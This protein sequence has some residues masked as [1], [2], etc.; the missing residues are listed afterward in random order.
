MIFAVNLSYHRPIH[1]SCIYLKKYKVYKTSCPANSYNANQA[2]QDFFLVL[3][4]LVLIILV[5][6]ILV[7]IIVCS[8]LELIGILQSCTAIYKLKMGI[9]NIK[10]YP[11]LFPS[12]H[13]EDLGS[14][15]SEIQTLQE[16]SLSMN[17]KLKN[18]QVSSHYMLR[19]LTRL[20]T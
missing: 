10:I 9:H 11:C 4:I 3:I 19:N 16:Q 8:F 5:L 13:Q 18:R 20:C 12:I 17:I 2:G 7:L 6:I 1:V 15:S 14:I